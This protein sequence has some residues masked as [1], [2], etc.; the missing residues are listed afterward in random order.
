MPN[1]AQDKIVMDP[2]KGVIYTLV[3]NSWVPRKMT[4]AE[5]QQYAPKTSVPRGASNVGTPTKTQAEEHPWAAAFNEGATGSPELASLG[6]RLESLRQGIGN[7]PVGTAV[8][9]LKGMGE[10]QLEAVN[11]YGYKDPRKYVAAIPVVGPGLAHAGEEPGMTGI[12]RILGMIA[13]GAIGSKT[14]EIPGKVAGA[15]ERIGT[16]A[17]DIPNVAPRVAQ[18][19]TG[20]KYATNKLEKAAGEKTAAY[21]KATAD[22]AAEVEEQRAAKEARDAS[23]LAKNTAENKRSLV[24]SRAEHEADTLKHKESVRKQA[25]KY[26]E[27]VAEK[28]KIET[29]NAQLEAQRKGLEQNVAET[30]KRFTENTK[31]VI[32]NAKTAFDAEY[33]DFDRKVLGKD[34]HNP[35]G[36]AQS[37]LTSFA[38]AVKDAKDNLIEGSP[39]KIKQFESIIN[40]AS[41]GKE[42]VDV[43]ENRMNIAPGKTLP[44]VDL[45]GFV[46]ELD[47]AIYNRDLLPDV[48][49]ALKA[50]AEKGKAEVL[51][52]VKA[53]GGDSAVNSLKD[54]NSRYSDYLTDWRDTSSVNPLP[55]IRNN[56][57]EG[58]VQNNPQVLADL[59][60]AQMLKGDKGKTALTLLNKYKKFGASPEILD[61]YRKAVEQ[62]DALEK[63]KKV[64]GVKRPD[65][66]A[67]SKAVKI[68]LSENPKAEPFKPRGREPEAPE[69]FNR[70]KTMRDELERR[71]NAAGHVGSVF[72]IIRAISDALHGNF[73]GAMTAAEQAASIQAIK[74][75]LTS[76]KS[77]NYLS[78]D[79]R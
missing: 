65:Y 51:K 37:D 2:K 78:R 27:D 42:F 48:R 44:T 12:M 11:K 28:K 10:G 29:E 75:L 21:E 20:A 34:E 67:P 43:S 72:P 50:V 46:T 54:L 68:D 16:A 32:D 47:S 74:A 40:L 59:D 39:E 33:G 63:M 31:Q 26:A 55:K 35:K 6:K 57:L 38:N 23:E 62:L 66:K 30:S 69:A 60:V 3:N 13:G 79:V 14:G 5:V 8:D 56:L 77:L 4:P 49:N 15:A 17:E 36:T 71:L 25:K 58:V 70:Q 1:T 61:S 19:V 9:T 22:R 64:P 76:D 45:R 18:N 73:G 7:D 53:I 41:K 24:Q 52:T